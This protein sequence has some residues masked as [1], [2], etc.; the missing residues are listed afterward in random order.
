MQYFTSYRNA[1]ATHIPYDYQGS[2]LQHLY[3]PRGASH[4]GF[5]AGY[6]S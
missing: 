1:I 3:C 5:Y 6:I 2:S 4:L